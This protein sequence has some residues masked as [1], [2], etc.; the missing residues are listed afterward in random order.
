MPL[1]ALSGRTNRRNIGG[2]SV[3]TQAKFSIAIS[4][5]T[6]KS[7]RVNAALGKTV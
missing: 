7:V 3:P 1:S 6:K 5:T 2:K 4:S